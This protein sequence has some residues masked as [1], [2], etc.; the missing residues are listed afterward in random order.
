VAALA[1]LAFLHLA[2]PGG[3]RAGAGQPATRAADAG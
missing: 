1:G 3:K 2:L